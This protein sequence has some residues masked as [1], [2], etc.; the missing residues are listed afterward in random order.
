MTSRMLS[1][2]FAFG[3]HLIAA[4][5]LSAP[6]EAQVGAVGQGTAQVGMAQF[7][8]R[9]AVAYAGRPGPKTPGAGSGSPGPPDFGGATVPKQS[10]RVGWSIT[11]LTLPEASGGE[12]TVTYALSAPP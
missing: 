3:T 6:A 5:L 1:T 8:D 7:G 12:G 2:A 4:Q 11:T 10:Y 9:M